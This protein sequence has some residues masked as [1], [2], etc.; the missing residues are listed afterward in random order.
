MCQKGDQIPLRGKNEV[1]KL[2]KFSKRRI[3]Q[4]FELIMS[5]QNLQYWIRAGTNKLLLYGPDRKYF[6]HCGPLGFYCATTQ[7]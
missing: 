2:T 3:F 4:T 1:K 7:L 5:I 6:R